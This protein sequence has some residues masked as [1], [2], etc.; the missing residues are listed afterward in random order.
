MLTLILLACAITEPDTATPYP[1]SIRGQCFAY[2]AM[3][4]HCWANTAPDFWACDRREVGL[5][6]AREWPYLSNP[7]GECEVALIRG[8]CDPATTDPDAPFVSLVGALAACADA[9][10]E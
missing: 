1:A 5:F 6:C 2:A 3:E 9:A 8:S 10:Q 7:P 4:C